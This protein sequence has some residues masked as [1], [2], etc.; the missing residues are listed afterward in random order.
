M[1][2]CESV[3]GRLPSETELDYAAADGAAKQLYAG[4]SD[5]LSVD[6]FASY[7]ENSRG[8]AYPVGNKAPNEFGL[9]DMSG[10]VAEW[11]GELYQRYPENA[12]D[13]VRVDRTC[14]DRRL[15]RGGSV[16]AGGGGRPVAEG[17]RGVVGGK[18]LRPDG[19]FGRRGFGRLVEYLGVLVERGPGKDQPLRGFGLSFRMGRRRIGS[20]VVSLPGLLLVEPPEAFVIMGGGGLK[21][22]VFQIRQHVRP[23]NVGLI[24]QIEVVGFDELDQWQ[25]AG[26]RNKC[27]HRYVLLAVE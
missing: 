24:L 5:S 13:A 26:S 27:Y 2:V 7:R 1:A 12:V 23:K 20:A 19:D 11:I 3:G 25:L 17:G 6:L 10:N 14:L 18:G 21:A 8:E 4:T 15:M 9:Y 16:G 22:T